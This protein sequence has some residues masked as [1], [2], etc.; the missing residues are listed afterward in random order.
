MNK[1]KETSIEKIKAAIETLKGKGITTTQLNVST[2]TG[3]STRTIKKYWKDIQP[4]NRVKLLKDNRVKVP[5][6]SV[7][8]S[9]T[10]FDRF[11]R[12]TYKS[13]M[14]ISYVNPSEF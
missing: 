12:R 1:T 5:I 2:E 8:F 7:K 11:K 9:D 14:G 3:L 4:D 13:T 6:N 10:G